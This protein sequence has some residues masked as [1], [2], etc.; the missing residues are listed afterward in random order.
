MARRPGNWQPS[1]DLGLPKTAP[2][3]RVEYD[4]ESAPRRTAPAERA[5]ASSHRPRSD[6]GE[7]PWWSRAQAAVTAPRTPST[8]ISFA[9]LWRGLLREADWTAELPPAHAALLEAMVRGLDVR[10]GVVEAGVGAARERPHRVQLRLVPFTAAEWARIVRHVVDAGAVESLLAELSESR[11]ALALVD[12]CDSLSLTLA[13]R[14]LALVSAACTCGA[15]KMRCDHVLA[16][17]LAFARRIGTEPSA[18]L[19][20]RGAAPD[21][22]RGLSSRILEEVS[23]AEQASNEAPPVDPFVAPTPLV[24]DLASLPAPRPRQPLPPVDGWRGSESFDALSRR[25]VNAVRSALSEG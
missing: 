1:L 17:H 23:R 24:L 3:T 12:A 6:S 22:L 20:F 2:E 16:T 4:R 8:A 21:E 19:A 25:L 18:L 7:S 10:P 14:S 15:A 11:V 5:P 13:P 9:N